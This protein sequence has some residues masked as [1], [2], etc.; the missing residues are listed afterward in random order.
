MFG[1]DTTVLDNLLNMISIKH[2]ASRLMNITVLNGEIPSELPQ[3]KIPQ[4]SGEK[5]VSTYEFI[6]Q[7]YSCKQT[8]KARN[9]SDILGWTK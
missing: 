1:W 2:S 9:V 5:D 8:N 3:Q 4:I 7:L 6:P